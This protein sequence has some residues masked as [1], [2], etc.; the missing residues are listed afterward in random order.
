MEY[1]WKYCYFNWLHSTL[2][3]HLSSI[4]ISS[5]IK[6]LAFMKSPEIIVLFSGG[7][8]SWLK[9]KFMKVPTRPVRKKVISQLCFFAITISQTKYIVLCLIFMQ[10]CTEECNKEKKCRQEKLMNN[11][12]ILTN[13]CN[14]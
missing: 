9:I 8:S 11:Y 1:I 2:L 14:Q 13:L 7:N 10:L 6:L 3:Y 5:L 12:R 4:Q